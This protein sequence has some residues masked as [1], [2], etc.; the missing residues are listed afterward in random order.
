MRKPEVIALQITVIVSSLL[1]IGLLASIVYDN[2]VHTEDITYI[3]NEQYIGNIEANGV[4]YTNVLI[5][6]ASPL[7]WNGDS[8]ETRENK[9]F[10]FANEHEIREDLEPGKPIIMTW[11]YPLRGNKHIIEVRKF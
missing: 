4:N 8:F 10:Y 3:M 11:N 5:I 6:E 7:Y 2:T 9:L 1:V